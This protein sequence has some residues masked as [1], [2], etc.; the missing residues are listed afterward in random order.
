[1]NYHKSIL[2]YLHSMDINWSDDS[3]YHGYIVVRKEN[4]FVS[5]GEMTIHDPIGLWMLLQTDMYHIQLTKYT[6]IHPLFGYYV[7]IDEFIEECISYMYKLK[8]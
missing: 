3:T 7:T 4:P 6:G 5:L 1:M 2:E 8:Q